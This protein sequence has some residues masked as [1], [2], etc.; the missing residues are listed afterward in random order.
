MK[1]TPRNATSSRAAT[2][3]RVVADTGGTHGNDS[4]TS[5]R[6]EKEGWRREEAGRAQGKGARPARGRGTAGSAAATPRVLPGQGPS[7]AEGA[8]RVREPARDHRRRADRAQ[9]R[10]RR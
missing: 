7:E 10:S 3:S 1:T 9:R 2:R 5:E 6:R 4:E 8:V